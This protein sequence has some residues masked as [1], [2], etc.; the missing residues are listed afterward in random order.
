MTATIDH[1]ASDAP[2]QPARPRHRT[3]SWRFAMRLA[4]REVRRRPGR[5]LLV[6][7]L[8]AIPVCGMTVVTVLV[9]TN[10]DSA[11]EAWARRFGNAD[12]VG[13]TGLGVDGTSRVEVGA[14]PSQS[15][16]AI[17][18]SRRHA[19][20]HCAPQRFPDRAGIEQRR[21][22]PRR[23]QRPRPERSRSPTAS[24][25]CGRVAFPRA[26]ARPCSPP[27]SPARSAWASATRYGSATR[28][29][30]RRSSASA[31][32]PRTGTTVSS[33]CAATS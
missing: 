13:S 8:V 2:P 12:L 26:P 15:L 20:R 32:S 19:H 33:P 24:C 29:G 28:R 3:S 10:N 4:R 5:T 7:L 6:M 16:P 17:I 27:C 22:A 23:R 30:P 9:R 1:A 11:T 18:A 21:G 25:C 31:S 14:S